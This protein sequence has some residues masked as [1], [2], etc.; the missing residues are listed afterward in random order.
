M[1]TKTKFSQ[2]SSVYVV[3][4]SAFKLAKTPSALKPLIQMKKKNQEKT[5]EKQL[6]RKIFSIGI[7]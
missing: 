3:K 1:C 7:N 2:V 5:Q 6:K 4:K